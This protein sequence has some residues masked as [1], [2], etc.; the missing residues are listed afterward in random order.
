S[1]A[2][3]GAPVPPSNTDPAGSDTS[4]SLLPLY[5]PPS[6]TAPPHVD[7]EPLVPISTDARPALPATITGDDGRD[8]TVTDVSRILP[9]W[10]NLSEVVFTL[11]L[12]ANVVGR[13]VA[14][15]FNEV[16]DLPVVTHGH[17]V[18]AESVLSL[19][20]T[21][22]LAQTDTG[23]PEAIEHIRNAGVPV[24][25]VK[26]PESFADIDERITLVAA[27]LGVGDLGVQLIE[28]THTEI[29]EVQATIP[30]GDPP[31]IAFLYLRGTA[32]VYLIAGP[33]SGADSMIAAAGGVDAGT[34]MGLE[35]PFTPLTSEA[36]VVAAPDVILMT[37]TGLASVGGVDGLVKI[38]GVAQTPAGID[39]RVITVED[40]LLYSFGSRTPEALR[41]MIEQIYGAP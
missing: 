4:T 5:V 17:D 26:A 33:G 19:R 8:V 36:F 11:G 9:L 24:V 12:G 37:T 22:V 6:T 16:E 35:R 10:G 7:T 23:P 41:E 21:V 2:T 25:V 38:P 15:T 14:A 20:P 31:R 3:G 29:A 30:A 1:V 34:A 28:R 18:S 39:R 32:G 27:A 40:G 13:D